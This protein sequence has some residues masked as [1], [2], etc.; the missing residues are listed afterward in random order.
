M[1]LFSVEDIISCLEDKNVQC[2]EHVEESLRLSSNLAVGDQGATLRAIAAQLMCNIREATAAGEGG[3][4]FVDNANPFNQTTHP[5]K[6]GAIINILEDTTPATMNISS[7]KTHPDLS[8]TILTFPQ[9]IWSDF[10]ELTIGA[11]NGSAIV[12]FWSELTV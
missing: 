3:S 9:V 11:G 7:G 6:R 12:Y 8:G 1:N 4:I 2:S 5:G 10:T